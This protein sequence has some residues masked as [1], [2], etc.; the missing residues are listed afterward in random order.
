MP[1]MRILKSRSPRVTYS[2][3]CGR[4]NTGASQHSPVRDCRSAASGSVT[5]AEVDGLRS[6][7]LTDAEVLDITLAATARSF[8]SKTLDALN[9]EPD[10]VYAGLQT[11]VRL[12]LTVGRTFDSLSSEGE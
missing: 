11:D 7:G 3:N 4:Q 10:I 2:T 1:H 8:F 5:Q 6:F 12:A 9:A